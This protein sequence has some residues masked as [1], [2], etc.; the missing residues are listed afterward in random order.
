MFTQQAK[1]EITDFFRQFVT[2]A[3]YDTGFSYAVASVGLDRDL[4]DN[5]LVIGLAYVAGYAAACRL[6]NTWMTPQW[7]I[8]EAMERAAGILLAQ[9]RSSSLEYANQCHTWTAEMK[10]E[11][12]RKVA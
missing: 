8:C 11:L 10:H 4:D 6:A 7:S 12:A 5:D 9:A 3:L 1:R 2:S